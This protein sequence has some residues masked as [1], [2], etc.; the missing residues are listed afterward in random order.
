VLRCQTVVQHDPRRAHLLAPLLA[1]LGLDTQI[2]EDPGAA[3]ARRSPWRCYR[4]CLD[5]LDPDTSHLLVV[6]DDAVVCRDFPAVLDLVIAA[7]PGDP[8]ALFVPG[9]GSNAR[10]VLAACQNGQRWC[11]L[12]PLTWVPA[13]AIVWPRQHIGSLLDFYDERN[14]PATRTAD[15]GIIGDWAKDTGTRVV[16]CVPSLVDHPDTVRSLVGTA[17]FHGLNPARCAACWI[18]EDLSPLTL[19]WG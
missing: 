14:Y 4:A 11:E 16:A 7:H 13:V 5:A 15:D 9:V 17:H 18:G 12:D 6:Q 2:V 1:A 19:Q 10:S 3:D 8:V